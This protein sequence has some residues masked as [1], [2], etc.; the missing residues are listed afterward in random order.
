M[1]NLPYDR[2]AFRMCLHGGSRTGFSGYRHGFSRNRLCKWS[3]PIRDVEFGGRGTGGY[4]FGLRSGA[5]GTFQT[6][7][8]N[9]I[10]LSAHSFEPGS[11]AQ[12]RGKG[13]EYTVETFGR[14]EENGSFAVEFE[15]G[16]RFNLYQI[17]ANITLGVGL[18]L[19]VN[20]AEM[21]DFILGIFQV[22]I[23]QDD[24]Q[25]REDR[26]A[27]FLH[28]L[29]V[30]ETLQSQPKEPITFIKPTIDKTEEIQL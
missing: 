19:G 23:L 12:S 15:E 1:L 6:S 16:G 21:A 27:E 9:V 25:A 26:R 17:E 13:Y 22:D 11:F 10:L 28:Q 18:R 8:A 7:D 14:S 4:G 2:H 30:L 5:I 20:F 29:E 3:S 24:L